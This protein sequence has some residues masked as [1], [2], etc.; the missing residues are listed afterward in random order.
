MCK[1]LDPDVEVKLPKKRQPWPSRSGTT[2]QACE[3]LALHVKTSFA[4]R[5]PVQPG[6]VPNLRLTACGSSKTTVHRD[7]SAVTTAK[8]N[9]SMAWL[10]NLRSDVATRLSS[11]LASRASCKMTSALAHKQG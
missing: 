9:F 1:L 3:A 4:V 7:L 2:T 6:S 5:L 8:Q 10:W 11:W